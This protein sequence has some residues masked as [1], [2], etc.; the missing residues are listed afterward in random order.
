MRIGL[1]WRLVAIGIAIC[2]LP[3]YAS[4]SKISANLQEVLR[5]ARPDEP[6]VVWVYFTDKGDA[7]LKGNALSPRLVTERAL[8]RRS[9]VLPHD[10]LVGHAD[11]PLEETYID[12]VVSAGGHVRQRSRWLNAL[13]V[14]ATPAALDAI[15]GL[16][17]VQSLELVGRY[18][19]DPVRGASPEPA[20]PAPSLRKAEGQTGLDY[21]P[22]LAQVSLLNVPA[23]HDMGNSAQGIIIGVFDNGF[24]L[25]TH[26]A[27]ASMNILATRDFVDKKTSVIP[28]DPSSSFGSHGV[29]TLSTIGGFKPGQLIGPAYGATFILARTE[30][31]SSETPFEEDNWVAGIEWAESLGVQV[32]ST[33]LGYLTYDPPYTSWTWQDMDGKTTPVTRAAAMAVR[34]GVIVVNSAGNNGSNTS[35]NTLNAPADADSVLSVGAVSPAGVRASFSSVGPTTSVPPH[36]KPDVMA[37][38]TSVYV[39]SSTNPTGYVNDQ[40]TSFSCPL[41]AGVA[42]LLLKANPAAEPMK[43]VEAMK[44]TATQASA[45]DNL[46]GWG[47]IDAAKALTYLSLSDTGNDETAPLTF[48]L[49]QNFP[50][51]FNPGTDI[52]Y[53]LR[54]EA[55]VTLKVFDILGREV[56]TLVSTNQSAGLYLRRWDGTNDDGRAVAGG[57]YF[58]RL[59]ARESTGRS[60]AGTRKMVL[61]R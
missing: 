22:S 24:R 30:N 54:I 4:S 9:K 37:T 61:V 6:L 23:L 48:N 14:T 1:S 11:L 44:M 17:F 43:I 15:A 21:G 59:E 53:N 57:I 40:G 51:P 12:R 49:H 13:S 46:N 7:G 3:L 47:I 32:T 50:N 55:L 34:R 45:P 10:Q 16:P 27:F 42:A 56:R 35:H 8:E 5:S 58:Y 18:R 33:S 31:D 29:N 2:T 39:A 25:L 36:T 28:N 60:S 38:G 19:R 41:A 20:A 52:T 26:E